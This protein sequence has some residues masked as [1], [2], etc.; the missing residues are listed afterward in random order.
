MAQAERKRPLVHKIVVIGDAQSGKSSLLFRFIHR[1]FSPNIETTVLASFYSKIL[2]TG[3]RMNIWDT[4]GQER[5]RSMLPAYLKNIDL[6]IF[7]F[8]TTKMQSFASLR[9]Y[10][11]EWTENHATTGNRMD[12]SCVMI[13]NKTDLSQKREVTY[14]EAY[15]FA[16]NHSMPYLETSVKNGNGV[17]EA[18]TTVVKLVTT[19]G[20]GGTQ[21]EP[22]EPADSVNNTIKLETPSKTNRYFN[23]ACTIV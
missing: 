8:D 21:V 3:D 18:W 4:A 19:G 5:Y 15:A 12:Y 16:T 22:V 9:D 13:G 2:A 11:L 7:V 17:D 10:W 23:C 14:E 20:V 6:I 1:R